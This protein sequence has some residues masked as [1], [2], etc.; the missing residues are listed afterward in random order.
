[1]D[2]P[3]KVSQKVK[4]VES[5]IKDLTYDIGQKQSFIKQ[6]QDKMIEYAEQKVY[7][8][9][10]ELMEKQSIEAANV[11]LKEDFD[12]MLD[13]QARLKELNE[14]FNQLFPE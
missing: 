1:M 4:E 2:T 7:F 6:S 8:T 12:L 14:S 9:E 5:E 11:F 13:L 3:Q 10:K